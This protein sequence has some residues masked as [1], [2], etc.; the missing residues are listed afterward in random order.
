M[1]E[2][3]GITPSVHKSVKRIQYRIKGSKGAFAFVGQYGKSLMNGLSQSTAENHEETLR[4]SMKWHAVLKSLLLL[5]L[6]N[7]LQQQ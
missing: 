1:K 5:H 4:I 3:A 7:S 2:H 6:A